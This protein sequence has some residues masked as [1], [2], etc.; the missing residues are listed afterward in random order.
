LNPKHGGGY[1][2]KVTHL[3]SEPKTQGI[4]F[5]LKLSNVHEEHNSR[6]P[7]WIFAANVENS[8]TLSVGVN[9]I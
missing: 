1:I 8:W 4:E 6:R 9:S 2:R 5:M 7:K 3:L